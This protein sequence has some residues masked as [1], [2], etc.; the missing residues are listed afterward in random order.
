MAPRWPAVAIAV[1]VPVVGAVI[2]SL[3]TPA[4]TLLSAGVEARG[5][6][7]AFGFGLA[8]LSWGVGTGL[9]N[10]AGGGLA[11]LAGDWSAFAAVA[12]VAAASAVVLG[13]KARRSEMAGTSVPDAV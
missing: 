5:V 2:G 10:V 13:R 6:D 1:L 8:N 9:G 4:M 11:E 7:P 3:W 12:L